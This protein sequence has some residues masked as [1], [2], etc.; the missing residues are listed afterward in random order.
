MSMKA[1]AQ[2]WNF[3][4]EL[5]NFIPPGGE[6]AWEGE[7]VE[8]EVMS[9]EIASGRY[10]SQAVSWRKRRQVLPRQKDSAKA[11]KIQ[12]LESLRI[13]LLRLRV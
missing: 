2:I 4:Q 6:A 11:P 10:E 9:S 3:S 1:V 12:V 5:A 13:A 7:R 8:L